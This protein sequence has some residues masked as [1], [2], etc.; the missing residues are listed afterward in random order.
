MSAK[1]QTRAARRIAAAS[2]AANIEVPAVPTPASNQDSD[3]E[4]A[5]LA[6]QKKP[7]GRKGGRAQG[8]R[9]RKAATSSRK[10][11]EDNL[12]DKTPVAAPGCTRKRAPSPEATA[13]TATQEP[14]LLTV[15][16]KKR[17][18]VEKPALSYK[19]Y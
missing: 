19:L 3:N 16:K 12:E 1:H 18:K 4:P 5:L 11:V 17:T 9:G 14:S 6:A 2:E 13:E 15:P 8:N 7:R 10:M